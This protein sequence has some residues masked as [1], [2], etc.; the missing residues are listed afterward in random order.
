MSILGVD[1]SRF[2]ARQTLRRDA[3]RSARRRPI[4]KVAYLVLPVTVC[5]VACT[6]TNSTSGKTPASESSSAAAGAAATTKVGEIIMVDGPLSASPLFAT[7]KTGADAAAKALGVSYQYSSPA[8]LSNFTVDFANLLKEAIGRKPAAIVVPE[9]NQSS[10]GPLI[11]QALSAG[12]PVI[13]FEEGSDQ[14]QQDGADGYVGINPNSDGTAAATQALADGVHHLLC[15]DIS[16]SNQGIQEKCDGAKAKLAAAGATEDQLNI[17]AA[18]NTNHQVMQ[19]DTQGYLASHSDIDGIYAAG[20]LP[21]DAIAAIKAL[22]KTGKIDIGT[23]DF[24]PS[25][26]ADMQNGSLNWVISSQ[27]YLEGYDAI[28]MAYQYVLYHLVPSGPVNTGGLTIDK[29]NLNTYVATAQKYP[30]ILGTG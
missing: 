21:E 22:G 8:D 2:G 3:S 23:E 5:L 12:I 14:W 17:P 9:F 4:G 28:Q 7:I 27:P 19:Q 6:S 25:S 29:S 26:I 30:N 13:E 10:E 18:D 24:E 11:K 15:I 1:G 16:P 20:G